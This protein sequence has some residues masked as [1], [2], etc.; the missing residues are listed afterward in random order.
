M[1]R[2]TRLF[3]AFLIGAAA[4]LYI[5]QGSALA[6][7]AANTANLGQVSGSFTIPTGGTG[8]YRVWS[9]IKAD[10]TN[11][12]N[13]SF[14]LEVDDTQ[15]NITVGDNTAISSTAWTWVDYK[16][17]STSGTTSKITLNLTAGSHS[18]KIYGRESGVKLDRIVFSAD[19]S[20]V[21]SGNGDNCATTTIPVTPPPV[22]SPPVIS[23]TFPG[24]STTPTSGNKYVVSNMKQFVFQPTISDASGI[25]SQSY[26]MNSQAVTLTGGTYTT[27]N[28]NGDYT[29]GVNATNNGNLTSTYSQLVRLRYPDVNRSNAVDA[30]DALTILKSWNSTTKPE[31]DFNA[32]NVIGSYD[33]LFVL[34]NWTQ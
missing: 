22:T 29:F 2:A 31:Y 7:C 3:S 14:T 4:P 16:D 8:N 28:A 20:C 19:V 32:D 13:N 18:Y 15:C 1:K 25:K 26:S 9:R 33:V 21:P 6:A 34:R 10:T 23:V 27:P 30:R 12:S 24:S 17:G 5:V 11:T